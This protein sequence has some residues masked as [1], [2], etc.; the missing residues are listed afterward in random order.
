MLRS[1]LLL[2]PRALASPIGLDP[3]IAKLTR[4]ELGGFH[5]DAIDPVHPACERHV[6]A[7]SPS[8]LLPV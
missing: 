2:A 4:Y 7:W 3:Q 1:R 5:L 8:F 6:F